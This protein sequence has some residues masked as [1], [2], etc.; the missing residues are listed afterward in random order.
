MVLITGQGTIDVAVRAISLGANG[1]LLKPFQPKELRRA[2]NDALEKVR[3]TWENQRLRTLLPLLA[4]GPQ[5]LAE[6]REEQ[7]LAVIC[8]QAAMHLD[9]D[10]AWLSLLS[11]DRQPTLHIHGDSQDRPTLR[12]A[13]EDASADAL[14][15]A[16]SVT[17]HLASEPDESQNLGLWSA[18]IGAY[19]SVPLRSAQGVLGVLGI[20]RVRGGRPFEDGDVHTL[21]LLGD[22]GRAALENARLHRAQLLQRYVSPQIADAILAGKTDVELKSR[23]KNLT[24][25]FSDIRGFTPLSEQKEPEELV[26]LLNEYLTAM[27][28]IVFKHGGTL[29]KYIGDG[30]MV[31]IGDPIEYEDHQERAIRMAVEMRTTLQELQQKWA[32]DGAEVLTIGIGIS[33]GYVTVGNIGSPTRADYTVLG[34]HVN[35]AARLADRAAAGQILVSERTLLMVQDLVTATPLDEVQLKGVS[36]PI[37]IYELAEL[38]GANAGP[39]R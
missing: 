26:E 7:L 39:T 29:D 6:T 27:T 22:Q 30:L 18:G 12:A 33:T 2:I 13:L 35:L 14:S 24:V 17:V 10:V 32:I 8:E 1:F 5:L 21:T 38:V 19:M 15:H 28:E 23:R 20:G 16:E 4:T 31:F 36:R 34:N 9:G 25:L 11:E 37:R 3:L